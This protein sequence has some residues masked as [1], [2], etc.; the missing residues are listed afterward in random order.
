MIVKNLVLGLA[1]VYLIVSLLTA[2]FTEKKT[3][4][5]SHALRA[6]L[7]IGMALYLL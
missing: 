4:G 1:I 2:I 5:L 7:I 3:S 6:C